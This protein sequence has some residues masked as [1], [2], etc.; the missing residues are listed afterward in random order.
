MCRESQN[1]QS[2]MMELVKKVM[3]LRVRS[4]WV[5]QRQM[6]QLVQKMG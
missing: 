4:H 1:R 6:G 2:L 3:S 5:E